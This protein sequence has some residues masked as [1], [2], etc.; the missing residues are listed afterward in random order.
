M[1]WNISVASATSAQGLSPLQ[2]GPSSSNQ[3]I[4][5]L[6]TIAA[7]IVIFYISSSSLRDGCWLR[8]KAGRSPPQSPNGMAS[9]H[10]AWWYT[11]SEGHK[12]RQIL[13]LFPLNGGAERKKGY[14][15]CTKQCPCRTSIEVDYTAYTAAA[16]K[17]T[18]G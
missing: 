4:C 6:L 3:A 9:E 1:S 13:V 8:G 5:P 14:P 7:W 17:T 12:L 18:G 2:L 11:R 16:G 15:R 10:A